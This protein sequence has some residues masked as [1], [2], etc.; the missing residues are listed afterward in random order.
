MNSGRGG[1][2]GGSGGLS[3]LEESHVVGESGQLLLVWNQRDRRRICEERRKQKGD[4]MRRGG[5]EPSRG[6]GGWEGD[7]PARLSSSIGVARPR[8][9]PSAAPAIARDLIA[10]TS[11]SVSPQRDFQPETF[12]TERGSAP[13]PAT[14]RTASESRGVPRARQMLRE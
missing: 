6:V 4:E 3:V 7:S 5:E 8:V 13:R 2:G 12:F 1:G 11:S 14:A 10:E 9:L